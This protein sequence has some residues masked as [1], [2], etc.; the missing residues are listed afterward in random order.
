[1]KVSFCM[2]AYK[3]AFLKEAIESILSQTLKDIELIVMDDNSPENLEEVV[4]GFD[5]SR[6]RYY[7]NKVNL[8]GKNPLYNYNKAFSYASGEYSVI[9]SD[10]DVYDPRFA[11]KMVSLADS[12]HDVDIFHCRICIIDGDGNLIKVGDLWPDYESCADYM[13]SR[14]VRR[15]AQ[16]MPEFL[17][18][19]SALKKISGMVE[20]PLA[21]YSDDATWFL[22][23]RDH[24]I[25]TT[26]EVLFHWRYSG[27]NISSRF[28]ITAKKV[29]AAEEYKTWL[30]KFIPT[31]KPLSHED[32]MVLKYAAEH[33]FEAVDQQTLY[34][35]DDTRFWLWLR[36]LIK[37]QLPPRLRLRTIRNRMRKV[38]HI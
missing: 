26:P 30:R 33:I 14:G 1:M 27:I 8:G 15:M 34:D 2:P 36:I 4:R 3:R 35:L 16:T 9:T 25:V 24:G 19:T 6:L 32:G 37:E 21:W 28:D 5:D 17:I 23:A 22:L 11:E 13:Y 38:F 31:V 12:N 7:K 10:D 29:Q 18:R 20:M